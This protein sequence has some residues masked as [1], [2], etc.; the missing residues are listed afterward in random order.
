MNVCNRVIKELKKSAD[1]EYKNFNSKIVGGNR[2]FIGV[3]MPVVK[4][5]VKA[6][7]PEEKIEYVANCEFTYYEDTLIYGLVIACFTFD[8]FFEYLPKYLEMVDSWGQI[9]S[10]VPAIRF[11]KK[12]GERLFSYIEKHILT[13][14]G[15]RLRF[16]IISLLDYFLENK[17]DF[18]LKTLEKIDGKG[19]YND[20]AIAW[21]I[22][23]AFVKNRNETITFLENDKLSSFTHNKAIRKICDSYRVSPEDKTF[24]K[25]LIRK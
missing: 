19:Y 14:N 9:D 15:F 4:S 23:V 3:R 6:L 25:K 20:M 24:V 16:C 13:D 10:F 11:A 18:I 5:I 1:V 7:S 22:S 12:D 17:F 8:K 21:L 2:D